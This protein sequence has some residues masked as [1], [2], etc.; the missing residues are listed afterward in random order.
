MIPPRAKRDFWS[1]ETEQAHT[2]AITY[3]Y[4]PGTK[5]GT[6]QYVERV[7]VLAGLMPAGRAAF[8]E[9]RE[10]SAIPRPVRAPYRDDFE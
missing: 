10:L 1:D 6:L 5:E 7:A 8:S 2:L 3:D 4:P 9:N